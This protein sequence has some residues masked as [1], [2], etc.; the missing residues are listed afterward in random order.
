MEISAL[1]SGSSGNCFYVA[2]NKTAILIDAGISAKQVI[3][4]LELLK[5]NPSKI[6]GIFIT[7]EHVDHVRGADVLARRLNI[8]IFATRSTIKSIN[9]CSNKEIIH[10]INSNAIIRMMGLKIEAFS[11]V[12]TAADPV[13]YNIYEE[14][15]ISIITDAG[16]VCKN[17]QK[18]IADCDFLCIEANHDE[19]MLEN[20]PYPYF[21][22]KWISSDKG[23]LSNKQAALS[24]LEYASK[25]LNTIILSHLSQTNN[26]PQIAL[27]TFT[28]IIK[29]RFNFNPN[30]SV[31]LR[32]NPT[33]L[34]KI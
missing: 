28:S 21:L 5:I 4:K 30:I 20:G 9:L 24:V 6:K 7:H 29:Q 34:F 8:P 27:N 15:K 1:A 12:H 18:N 11:K 33:K 22:K 13:S 16:H 2:N 17:I 25:K 10:P 32:E 26:T 14:K 31:S 19:L 3:E 23:H